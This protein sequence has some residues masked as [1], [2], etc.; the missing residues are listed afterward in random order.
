MDFYLDGKTDLSF[1]Y[2][3]RLNERKHLEKLKP[4]THAH[5]FLVFLPA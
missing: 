4:S 1:I 5:T 2:V 3:K